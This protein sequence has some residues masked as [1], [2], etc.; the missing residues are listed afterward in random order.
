[1]SRA[2][3]REP[4]GGEAFEDLLDRSVSPHHLVTPAG[5]ARMDAEIVSLEKRVTDA[6]ARDD[7][8]EVAR[9]LAICATGRPAG[10]R[11]R[12]C[13]RPPIRPTS[14]SE[15]KSLSSGRMDGNRPTASSV[16]MR[17]IHKGSLSY[18]SP[19]LRPSWARRGI[20]SRSDRGRPKSS[21]SE[22]EIEPQLRQDP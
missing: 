4:E 3:V 21:R 6:Q 16:R 11:P 22:P 10:S 12:W 2:F 19:R 1:M 8:A 17:P 5:L 7:K 9:F 18:V 13:P 15:P 14:A 20:P